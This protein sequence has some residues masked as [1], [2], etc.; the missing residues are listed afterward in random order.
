MEKQPQ[1]VELKAPPTLSLEQKLTPEEIATFFEQSSDRAMAVIWGAIVENRLTNVIRLLM[2]RDAQAVA[3][4]LFRPTGPLG[5]FG[6][7]I[8]LAYM[9][10]MI[11]P[12]S[13][14]DLLIVSRIRNGFA[15]DISKISFDDH[16]ISDLIKNMKMYAIVNK[17][18]KEASERI[19]DGKSKGTSDVIASRRFN[20]SMRDSYKQSIRFILHALTDFERSI[21][22]A[23]KSMNEPEPTSPSPDID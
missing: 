18:G 20:N 13:F 21:K 10:R 19:K 23:E 17:M 1:K 11:E 6:T 16:Q 7:K 5:T 9:L 2:R 15:H 22:L 3:T 8:R 4:E 14:N 12:D